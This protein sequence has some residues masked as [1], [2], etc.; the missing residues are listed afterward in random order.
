MQPVSGW[1]GIRDA[2]TP[3]QYLI[4]GTSDANGLLY[5]GPI[6]GAGGTSYSVNYPGA[7]STSVY[8]P[9]VLANGTSCGWSAATRPPA[10]Q[11][12]RLRLPGDDR[13]PLECAATTRRSTIPARRTPTSTARWA[14]SRS[15]TPTARRMPDRD[16]PRVPLQHLAGHDPDRHRLSGLDDPPRPTASGTTAARATRSPAAIPCSC[17]PG[18]ALAQGYLVNYDSVDRAIHRLDVVRRPGRPGRPVARHPL[19]GHQQSRAGRLYPACRRDGFRIE[20]GPS[21]RR[22][23]PSGAIPTARSAPPTGST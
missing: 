20:H 5:V 14:T 16:G 3:G 4:T 10:R 17:S 22:W 12:P 1:Q 9:D 23:R 2:G 7:T 11:R 8:G 6:S 21:R 13:R 19:P 18:K 15:A